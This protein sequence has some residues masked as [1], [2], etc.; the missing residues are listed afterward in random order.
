[1]NEQNETQ[2]L[3]LRTRYRENQYDGEACLLVYDLDSFDDAL[4]GSDVKQVFEQRAGT[5]NIF[6]AAPFLSNET[7]RERLKAGVALQRATAYMSAKTGRVYLLEVQVDAATRAVSITASMLH[8]NADTAEVRFEAAKPLDAA[9]RE[10]WLFHLFD[11]NEGL[12]VAPPGVHFRKS[13]NKHADKFLRAANTLTSSSACGLLAIFALATLP[14]RSP[15]RILVDTAPLLSLAY[16]MMRVAKRHG[17]WEADVPTRSFSSYGGQSKMRRLSVNDVILISATTSGSL[18]ESLKAQQANE[19]SIVTLFFLCSMGATRPHN[20]LCDLTVTPERGFGYQPVKNHPAVGCSL[21]ASDFILAEFE[22]DQFLLQQRNH[23]LLKFV[24]TTQADDTRSTLT[25][26][27]EVRATEVVMRP[28]A[29]RPSTIEINEAH[30][31]TC[32]AIRKDLIRNLRR[33]LPQ[34]LALVVRVRIT[35]SQ[36]SSLIA[37]AGIGPAVAHASFIDWPDLAAHPALGEGQGVLVVFGCL[38]SHT[39][40]RQINASLRSKVNN[41]NVAYVSAL[42]IAET[43]EQYRDIKMFLGFGERGADTFTYRDARKVALP[44]R[45]ADKNPWAEE[46][47]LLNDL[48]SQQIVELE[49]R[50]QVL[51]T[52]ITA[53]NGLF[54]PGLTGPLAIQRDFV[55]L[56]TAAGTGDISQAD[57]FAVVSN[58]FA[59]ARSGSNDLSRKTNDTVPLAQS[60]YGHIL[61]TP[62]AFMTFNDG[63]LKACLLRAARKSD[64]MY[65]VDA[66][67][68]N[69]ILEIVLAEIAGWPVGTGDALPEMLVALA[70]GRLRL[71]E[72]DSALIRTNAL[73]AGLPPYMAAL[74][75]AIPQR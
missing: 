20:V 42:T 27:H 70:T 74:A 53:R 21:C 50:R 52:E 30:L 55:Y 4:V 51:S 49:A 54:W 45:G 60:V 58:L 47:D 9:L 22:G 2:G 34:P 63:V 48:G 32:P 72:T 26:L 11:A 68:S 23:R 43:P 33:Y 71:R 19:D 56:D 75:R 61:L 24:R 66:G 6:I 46:L 12:V 25:E 39:V 41:G 31:L 1:M 67:Y 17:I 35:Q 73:A 69:R 40:A 14:P 13:S 62:E 44:I 3:W 5:A 64:L 29:T 28:D 16:A 36:L 8:W 10:G 18:A 57:V 65:E 37:D 38:S 15:K 59:A 7:C